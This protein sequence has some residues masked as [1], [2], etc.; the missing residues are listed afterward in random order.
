M[1]KSSTRILSV[2][3]TL[4][5]VVLAVTGC[6]NTANNQ[7]QSSVSS[8]A[9][10]SSQ[11]ATTTAPAKKVNFTYATFIGEAEKDMVGIV[12]KDYT[13]KN[14]NVTVETQVFDHDTY[15]KKLPIMS[16]SN[17]LPDL[18]WWNSNLIVEAY[19]KTKSVADLTPF[20]DSDFKASVLDSGW[21]NQTTKDGKIVAFPA[22]IN[23]QAWMLNKALFD[24]YNLDI[25][26]TIDDLKACVKVFKAN[27]V[28]TIAQGT[29]DSSM[30]T[31][32][33]EEFLTAWGSMDPAVTDAMFNTRTMKFADAPFL[34]AF[35]AIGELADLG[36]FPANNSTLKFD[37]AVAMFAAGNAAMISIPSDQMAKLI[38]TPI[39]KDLVYVRGFEFPNSTYDQKRLVASVSNGYGVS[40]NAAND[41]DKIAA[42]V[43][44]NKYRFTEDGVKLTLQA[45]AVLP[46]KA[47][48]NIDMSL[49]S[50]AVT[51]QQKLA[52]NPD[53][54]IVPE[55]NAYASYDVWDKNWEALASKY[56]YAVIALENGLIDGS[57][58]IKDIPAEANK[59]DKV[60]DGLYKQ[61]KATKK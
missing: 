14:P 52:A 8:T 46:A 12:I 35:T 9:T 56:F 27:N 32:G 34:P 26:K 25:P 19:D 57:K 2:M 29:A 58:K 42:I 30:P 60:T 1:K 20:I 43:A 16:A 22:E 13:T 53:V 50:K 11:A 49:Y 55:T 40:A 37:A 6:G 38:G 36:A 54:H 7:N 18:F 5:F 33:T 45:G 24:K 10:A 48:A 15:Q 3:I 21:I 17:T 44:I 47:T 23:M 41:P 51:E 4:L 31:W 39:E 59:I 28:V 61:W